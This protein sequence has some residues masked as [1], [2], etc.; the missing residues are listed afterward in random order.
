[1]QH[2]IIQ[3][4]GSFGMIVES[5]RGIF[6]LT[7]RTRRLEDPHSVELAGISECYITSYET[8]GCEWNSWASPLHQN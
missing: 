6:L 7:S 1:M 3:Y 2:G 8:S 5:R 4:L